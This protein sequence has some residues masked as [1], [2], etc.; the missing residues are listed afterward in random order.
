[1]AILN[2]P[3]LTID[4]DGSG[5][6]NQIFRISAILSGVENS[7]DWLFI[8]FY[9]VHVANILCLHID[10]GNPFHGEV[11]RPDRPSEQS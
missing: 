1:M 2:F 3:I 7:I 10:Q 11:D 9:R 4:I 6:V 5:N 8:D